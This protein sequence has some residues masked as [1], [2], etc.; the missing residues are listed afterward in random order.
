MP[1]CPLRRGTSSQE[2]SDFI[3][4]ATLTHE[5]LSRHPGG[6]RKIQGTFWPQEAAESKICHIFVISQR[7]SRR[8][9][10]QTENDCMEIPQCCETFSPGRFENLIGSFQG[11][12][13]LKK[14]IN[15]H[16]HPLS[17]IHLMVREWLV[18]FL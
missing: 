7:K 15:R 6:W 18:E 9:R 3:S 11:L 2:H 17:C 16:V 14:L 8:V 13:P 4:M 1:L 5:K 12:S 10:G